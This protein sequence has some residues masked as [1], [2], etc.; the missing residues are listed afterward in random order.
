VQ[1]PIWAGVTPEPLVSRKVA[2]CE[3][4]TEDYLRLH[5]E[6][7]PTTNPG[8]DEQKPDMRL[9]GWMSKHIIVMS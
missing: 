3:V 7:I 5:N 2:N 1:V 8:T 9:Q 4:G 6:Q